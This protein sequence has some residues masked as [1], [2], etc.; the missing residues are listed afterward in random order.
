MA[1]I[2]RDTEQFLEPLVLLE[3]EVVIGCRRF[4][5]GE[6]PLDPEER[7]FK[8]L[9]AD[10]Q[11]LLDASL[12]DLAVDGREQDALPRFSRDDEIKLDVADPAADIGDMRPFLY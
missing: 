2:Y 5:L 12:P 10:G 6:S 7:L 4:H 11:D 9:D 3:Q 8:V 1:E